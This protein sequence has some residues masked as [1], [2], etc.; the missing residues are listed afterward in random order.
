[1]KKLSDFERRNK[2]VNKLV[3]KIKIFEKNFPFE[4]VEAACVRYKTSNVER[5]RAKDAVKAAEERLLKA[6]RNLK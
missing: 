4:I 3:Q 6:K 5:R 2:E 1:M